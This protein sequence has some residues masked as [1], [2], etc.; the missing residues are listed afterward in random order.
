MNSG[1]DKS[2]SRKS[3]TVNS[4]K[5]NSVER[6]RSPVVDLNVKSKIRHLEQRHYLIKK[7]RERLEKEWKMST[8]ID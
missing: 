8:K 3:N 5:T 4:D 6:K 1:G 2:I 7:E